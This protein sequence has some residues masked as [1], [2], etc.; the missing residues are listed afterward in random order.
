MSP[1]GS[2]PQTPPTSVDAPG[3][4]IRRVPEDKARAGAAG[5][6]RRGQEETHTGR[7]RRARR[8]NR[9]LA[10]TYPYAVAELDFDS[11][12]Q[13]LVATVLSAQTTDVKVNAVTPGL[14][15]AYPTPQ[16]LAQAPH[17]AVEEIVRP[18]GFYRAK[19]RSIIALADR[20]VDEHD[21]EVP[22]TLEGLT[23]LPG[24]GRKTA[25]VV[26]GNAFGCPGLTVDTHF[27]RLARRF[28]F[29]EQED[30]VKVEHDVAALFPPKDWTMLSHRLIYHGR[31]ICHARRPACGVCPVA[32]LCP[33]YGAGETDP[34]AAARLL[35][36]EFAPGREQLH[37]RF[38]E[39]ATRRQLRVEGYGLGA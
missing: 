24:V 17:E 35:K 37:R 8:I 36:Y 23:A 27:G 31:R 16:D 10:E 28:G 33:S 13:L 9:I 19:T 25:F 21:G 11:P 26:L 30:P 39:G 5:R 4:A 29:T 34:E 38:L 15:A 6:R 12:F 2:A 22:D 1:T 20:L 14:F 32:D 3:P 18:L 7:V